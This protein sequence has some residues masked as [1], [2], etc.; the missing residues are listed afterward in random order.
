MPEQVGG[1]DPARGRS[2]PRLQLSTRPVRGRHH[3]GLQRNVRLLAQVRELH[4]IAELAP[5]DPAMGWAFSRRRV[6]PFVLT[7]A[8]DFVTTDDAQAPQGPH[9]NPGPSLPR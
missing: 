8:T 3:R 4:I 2:V 1:F 9:P 6:Q 7:S 5:Y